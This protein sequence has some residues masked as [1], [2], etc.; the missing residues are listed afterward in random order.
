MDASFWS[1]LVESD[2]GQTFLDLGSALGLY[3]DR[4]S[5]PQL[6]NQ[7][8]QL[9]LLEIRN[10][11]FMFFFFDKNNTYLAVILL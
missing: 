11:F 1:F 4:R 9:H 6:L 2:T 3:G 10:Y 7:L 5:E 8:E